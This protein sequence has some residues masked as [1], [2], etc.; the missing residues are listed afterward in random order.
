MMQAQ[1]CSD[2]TSTRPSTPTL[3]QTTMPD[4]VAA[5]VELAKMVIDRAR[6]DGDEKYNQELLNAA[7]DG[8]SAAIDELLARPGRPSV[9]SVAAKNG[10]TPLMAA[11][12]NGHIGTVE[13]LIEAGA[14]VNAARPSDGLT[15]LMAAAHSDCSKAVDALVRAGA[16]V[17]RRTTDS[18]GQT[19]LMAAARRGGVASV[20]VLLAAGAD[21]NAQRRSDGWTALMIAALLGKL[22]VLGTLLANG[23]R[24]QLR[25]AVGDDALDVARAY[26]HSDCVELLETFKRPIDEKN[27]L[28]NIAM[29]LAE[30]DLP[31]L[32]ML[33]IYE[34]AAV[35]REVMPSLMWQWE[36]AKAI[37]LYHRRG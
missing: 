12:Q 3:P 30:L 29:A 34:Q 33:A 36:T 4:I 13:R 8:A 11:A 15:P 31:V 7:R 19:A 22:A 6:S 5:G 28:I 24:L 2:C 10:W 17:D 1:L 20:D 32:Q 14:D 25:N 21:A 23:A 9:R 27:L 26:H 35:H 37:K 16:H 18:A